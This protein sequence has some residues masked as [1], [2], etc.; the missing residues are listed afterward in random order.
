M[1]RT[2]LREALRFG[3]HCPLVARRLVHLDAIQK[4]RAVVAAERE[5][6]GTRRN[7]RL[8]RRLAR[9][10]AQCTARLR[11]TRDGLPR[12]TPDVV[13]LDGTQ[14]IAR[15]VTACKRYTGLFLLRKKL[16]QSVY[17]RILE[18]DIFE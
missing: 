6:A 5:D 8:R 12:V 1:P 17:R 9:A 10:R 2:R 4:R 11:H 13:A 18:F 3:E 7:A 15:V 16:R 14:L